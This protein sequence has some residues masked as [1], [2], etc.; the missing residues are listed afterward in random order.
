MSLKSG[1]KVLHALHVRF[2][3]VK[4]ALLHCKN[5]LEYNVYHRCLCYFLNQINMY[6]PPGHPIIA[7]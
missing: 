2:T 4:N 3:F 7:I 6:F 1:Y 5:A